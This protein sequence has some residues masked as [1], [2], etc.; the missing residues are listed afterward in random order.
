MF[1]R[2]LIAALLP[3]L[4]VV[5]CST[6][7]GTAPPASAAPRSAATVLSDVADALGVADASSITYSGNA[8]NIRNSFRQTPNASPPWPY[9]DDITNYVRTIDL[10]QPASLATADTFAQNLFL[11]PAVA[12][13]YTQYIA[14][15]QTNWGQ[16][17]E[18]WLTPWGFLQ[19][20][21]ANA[22]EVSTQTI[23]GTEF[24]V[25]T[26][27]SPES[28]TSPSGLQY[29]V[30]G[31]V[32]G[33]NL[34]ERVETW[35]E[36]AFMGD[37]HVE[38]VYSDYRNLNGLMFPATIEQR[39][40]GGGI[41]GVNVTNASANPANLA[42]LMT[43]P[44]PAGGGG[45]GGGGPP[46]ELVQQL[47]DGVYLVV[48]GYVALVAEFEDHVLVIEAGQSE[49][50][51]QQI[52][53]QVKL[54]SP[55]KP[56][57]YIVNSHP[58]SDHTAGL[59]PFIREGATLVTHANNVDFLNMALSTPRTLLG[60]DTLS[61]QLEGVDGVAVY[62]DASM[63][64]ELHHIPNLHSDGMLVAYLPEQ[65]ILFQADF[66]LPQ[67]GADANPFV[68]SLAE[69]VA[70]TGLDFDRYLAV[71]AAQAPQT[72]ADLMATLA[73]RDAAYVVPS[74]TPANIQRAVASSA[75]SDDQR[76]RDAGRKPAEVLTLAAIDAGDR[77]VELA[78]FGHYYTTM[79]AEAVGPSGHVYML[80]MPWT[81]RFGGEA[82]RAFDLAH[83]N[84]SY[85][86]AHYNDVEFPQDVDAVMN[87]LFYHDL[88][89]GDVDVAAVNAKIFAALKPGGTYLV[90]DHKAEDGSGWRDA[91]TTHRIDAGTIRD[92]VVA[93]GFELAVDST[94]LANSEDDR[95]Q[96]IRAEGL[97]GMTDRAVLVFRKPNR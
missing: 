17:L 46:A 14:P 1:R 80:D 8:W 94:L 79:L 30:N 38:A 55:G 15:D 78:A 40:G 49:T 62:E 12:G 5:S 67:P 81:D 7:T 82:A 63:R 21:E 64:V 86:Q 60:E 84:V 36:D 93:A 92:E 83:D 18:I 76:A 66:T 24:T 95:T 48:G 32:N 2:V 77:V 97:R 37:M 26:W 4:I 19:G 3:M 68:I 87:V 27:M 45:F 88:A 74:D 28:Q 75:R 91:T 9:R 31:Y 34:I 39:R 33:R 13:K 57:R 25:V 35:V 10:A 23:D 29:T 61:P 51:G 89:Q 85:T 53:D 16:Q 72:K 41:F 69:Y 22:A 54:T 52:L 73:G 90:I 70:E 42:A 47:A 59:I 50:R 6:E 65:K 56:I 43:P 20:A 58:H 96:A 44:E 71:H 11:E